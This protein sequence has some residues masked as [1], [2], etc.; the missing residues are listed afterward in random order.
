MA[1]YIQLMY[2]KKMSYNSLVVFI[3]VVLSGIFPTIL[4]GQQ[5]SNV[6]FYQHQM[7]LYNPAASGI[8]E[9]IS[10]SSLYRSQWVGIEGAPKV[11][12]LA[13][14]IPGGESRLGYGATILS[15]QTFVESRLRLFTTFSYRLP[16]GKTTSLYLGIQGGGDH[17]N[18][19]IDNLN[20]ISSGD[21]N[22]KNFTRFYPNIG[23]G[24]YL[25]ME[26]YYFSLASPLLFRHKKEKEKEGI[27][28]NT[29]DAL[30]LYFSAGAKLPAF[31]NQNWNW[32]AYGLIRWV[33][34][35][36]T[37]IIFNAGLDFKGSEFTLAY[38]HDNSF[39]ATFLLDTSTSLSIGYSYQFSSVRMISKLNSGNH[40]LFLRFRFKEKPTE[41]EPKIPKEQVAL[42]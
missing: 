14:E 29:S 38:H 17:V 2:D 18:L 34:Y 20:V 26:K 3:G 4:L 1:L 11:H 16:I 37:S 24:A 25:K 30:Y 32:I 6:A 13:F 5:A 22:L 28:H 31:N 36:P 33:K 41:K 39:G 21:D 10:L 35:A 12:T 9:R 42:H 27:F 15:D 7:Q 8:N 23:V 40:E 19:N